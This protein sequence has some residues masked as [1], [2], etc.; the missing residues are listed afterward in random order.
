MARTFVVALLV[1]VS[2]LSPGSSRAQ[3]EDVFSSRD[4]ILVWYSPGLNSLGSVP[5]GNGD[6]GLNAWVEKNGDL[7][8]YIAK[9]DAWSENGRLLK[10]GKVR[11]SLSPALLADSASFRQELSLRDGCITLSAGRGEHSMSARLWVDALNPAIICEIQSRIPVTA[12]LTLEL[13]RK[14]RRQMLRSEEIESAY[15]LHGADGPPVFVEPDLILPHTNNR[16][17]WFHQNR[18]SVWKDNLSLQGLAAET[19]SISDPLLQRTF[20]GIIE[21]NGLEAVAD[22]VL[23]TTH[24]QKDIQISIY[25]HTSIHDTPEQWL[26]GVGERAR[27]ISAIPLEKR[28]ET[29]RAWWN[30]FWERSSILVSAPDS[31]R[32]AVTSAVTRGYMLQ[33]FVNACG[34]RGAM[35]IKFN[36]SLFT[37]DTYDRNAPS[38]G[39]DSDY[40][41]WGGPY[42]FQNTRLPY[43]SML[44]AGD[45]DMMKP[46]FDMYSS[47]LPL[48]ARATQRYYNHDGAFFPEVMN[49]WGTYTDENYGRQ[50]TGMPDGL[51]SNTY[52][53]YYWTAGLELSL[54]MLD[55]SEFHWS[56]T[57]VSQTLVPLA[58]AVLTFFDRHWPRDKAGIIRFEPAQALETYHA[59]VNPAPDI[60]GIRAVAERMFALPHNLTGPDQRAQWKEL[61]SSLPPLPTHVVRGDTLL[62]PATEYGT[63]A[64]IE[65]PELY[66]VFPFRLYGVDKP[67]LDLA[68]RTYAHRINTMNG[69]WAQHAIQAA[70]LGLAGESARLVAEN[71]ATWD[72]LCRFPAF[73]GPNYDWTP[74][75]DHGSVAA[76]ALQR[77]LVQ[78]EGDTILL[79]PAWPGGWDVDF[80]LHAPRETVIEARVRAG[81]IEHLN[82]LPHSRLKDI[83]VMD[84]ET[85]LIP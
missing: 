17:A 14:D 47:V 65:N 77:M 70:Y 25:P 71:F 8:F 20:G 66:A 73:W 58:S 68:R 32:E 82:V 57:F 27:T 10:L 6:I 67:G 62:A 69:G 53:R 79:L 18:R 12:R 49:F 48:R 38:R 72:S 78:Y 85:G 64:N 54:M 34:G 46:L 44:Q 19:I 75:Q 59:V 22:T 36:G 28:F 37:V 84:V 15:G 29:H 7:L 83:Q 16:L 39:I 13:W 51:T 23:Q 60:A 33:R 42:W 52:I 81:K 74:D 63:S 21:G 35:P 5:L 50:R 1:A 4:Q 2:L 24:P 80:R 26:G 31:V 76:I 40:R 9:S 30:T 61:L 41:R 55:F 3:G 45:S 43:W 56:E 11:V